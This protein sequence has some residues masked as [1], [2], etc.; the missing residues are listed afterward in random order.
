[1]SAM[2]TAGTPLVSVLTPVFNGE[3]FLP[4]C[5][6]SVRAQSYGRIE[7]VI[8]DN[9]STDG[10]GDWL[11]TR[12]DVRRRTLPDNRGGAGGFHEG[13]RWAVEETGADL[14]WLMDDDGLPEGE[15]LK[16]L[17]REEDLDFWGPLI[18]DEQDPQRLVFPIRL[19]GGTRAR[20]RLG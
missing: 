10:T 7:H 12:T 18:V 20:H 2:P 15:C 16:R 13:L 9:A 11:T 6:E 14:V 5:I 19:P 17:L 1:M 3:R 8:L 4:A